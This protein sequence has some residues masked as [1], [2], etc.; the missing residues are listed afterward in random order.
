M[1]H[2]RVADLFSA[3]RPL[4]IVTHADE[5]DLRKQVLV[6]LADRRPQMPLQQVYVH[7]ADDG[8]LFWIGV[9]AP[10]SEKVLLIDWLPVAA[11]SRS[12]LLENPTFLDRIEIHRWG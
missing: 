2:K 12:L 8:E 6:F 4:S 3:R 10:F 9:C 11:L 1:K 7:N 5:H